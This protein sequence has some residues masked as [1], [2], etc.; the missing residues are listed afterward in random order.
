MFNLIS[1]FD[2]VNEVKTFRSLRKTFKQS[3]T[4]HFNKMS[5]TPFTDTKHFHHKTFF[6]F[7][8]TKFYLDSSHRTLRFAQHSTDMNG[9]MERHIFLPYFFS[10]FNRIKFHSFS[11]SAFMNIAIIQL[12]L[13]QVLC[14]EWVMA[15]TMRKLFALSL[16]L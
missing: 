13:S 3:L 8:S 16:K 9:M 14:R 7:S 6:F 4:M 2:Y 1:V 12:L 11:S 15:F 5:S 10:F